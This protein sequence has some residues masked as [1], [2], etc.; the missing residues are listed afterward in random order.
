MTLET[1]IWELP[2]TMLYE[3]AQYCAPPTQR[4]SF[5]C[6]KIATLCKASHHR[7]MDE[8]TSAGIWNSVLKGDYGF[9]SSNSSENHDT[10]IRRRRS[11]KRLC[12]SPM[13]QVKD[14]HKLMQDNTEIAYYYLW[15]LSSS[16]NNNSA[17]KS[18][19]N[20]LTRV[21]LVRILNTYGPQLMYNKTMSS[22]GTF[23]VEVCRCRNAKSATAVLHCVQELVERRAALVNKA[24]NESNSCTLTAICVAAARGMPKIVQYLLSKGAATDRKCTG[25]FRLHTNSKRSLRCNDL[26]PLEFAEAMLKAE[27]EEGAKSTELRDLKSCIKLL[28]DSRK[29]DSMP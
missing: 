27:V 29:R 3:I 16:S 23:L 9:S 28:Q 26:T 22:G 24:T 5:L 21:N 4:A 15:E 18:S 17:S 20:S 6:Y 13:E 8:P 12:R 14:A 10:N 11:C 19:K 1:P 2:D 25:R 7:I